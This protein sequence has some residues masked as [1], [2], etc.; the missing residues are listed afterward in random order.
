MPNLIFRQ[1]PNLI[2]YKVQNSQKQGITCNYSI[3]DERKFLCQP[4]PLFIK[5]TNISKMYEIFNIEKFLVEKTLN[6]VLR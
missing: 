4:F 2:K 1:L 5:V 6:V 3:N